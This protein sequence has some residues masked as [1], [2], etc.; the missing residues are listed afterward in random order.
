MAFGGPIAAGIL[1]GV[2]DAQGI[3]AWRWLFIIEG[4]ASLLFGLVAFFLLLDF[5]SMRTGV[6][7]WL[8]TEIEQRVAVERMAMDHVSQPKAEQGVMAGLKLA[9]GDLN[10]WLFV[11]GFVRKS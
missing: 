6:A 9:V 2:G 11:G 1:S 7:R 4:A 5:P 10:T 8:L 3:Q